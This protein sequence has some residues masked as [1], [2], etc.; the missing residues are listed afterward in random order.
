[1]NK[2]FNFNTIKNCNKTFNSLRTLSYLTKN[3]Q[4]NSKQSTY[5]I[6]HVSSKSNFHSSSFV[7]NSKPNTLDQATS[8]IPQEKTVGT[9]QK[10]EFLAETK[11]LLNIVAKSLY[12]EKEVFVRELVSNS[13]DALEKLKYVQL[14]NQLPVTQNEIPLEIQISCNDITNTLTIQDTGYG[15]T[16][17]ELIKNLGTIAHSGSKV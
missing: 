1:M 12:S 16:K 13:S 2:L 9:A 6:R 5:Y 4:T 10:F 17:E 14:N 7:F 11:Q 3:S 8:D 15:M